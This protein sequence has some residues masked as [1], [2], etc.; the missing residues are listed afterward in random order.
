VDHRQERIGKNE[1]L[2]RE[3]NERVE[4]LNEAL[5]ATTEVMQLLCECGDEAC[6]DRI[7]MTIPEYEALRQEPT[8]FAVKPGHEVGDV[9]Q[10][11][12]R[13]ERYWVV[14]KR[15]G[16]PARLA[17]ERDPRASR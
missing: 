6:F 1:T 7:D 4:E 5:Q 11:L 10:V 8:H 13:T 16:E 17:E 15:S 9:E 2:F 12:E 14:R 3:V